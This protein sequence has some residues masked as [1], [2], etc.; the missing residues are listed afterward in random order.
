MIDDPQFQSRFQWTTPEQA[1]YEQLLFPVHVEGEAPPVPATAPTVGQHTAEVL[2][3]VLGY[4]DDHI[5]TLRAAGA[6]A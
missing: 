1:G 2:R 3:R 6:I 5:E 4:T